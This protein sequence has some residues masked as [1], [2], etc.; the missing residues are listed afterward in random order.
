M[1]GI[2]P[3]RLGVPIITQNVDALHERAGSRDVIDLH[4]LIDKEI[5]SSCGEVTARAEV[6]ARLSTPTRPTY[7]N[8]PG[9]S[10]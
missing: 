1:P 4:G 2:A 10:G 7:R 8:H 6:Q 9:R 3:A 5:C